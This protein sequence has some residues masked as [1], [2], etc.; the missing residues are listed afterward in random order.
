MCSKAGAAEQRT[1]LREEFW[2]VVA[3]TV[4]REFSPTKV[5][6]PFSFRPLKSNRREFSPTKAKENKNR[7]IKTRVFAH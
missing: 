2:P 4:G 7:G 5:E 3:L 1:D 6:R